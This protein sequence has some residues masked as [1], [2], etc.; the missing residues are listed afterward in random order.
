[1]QRGPPPPPGRVH[2]A[3][4]AVEQAGFALGGQVIGKY[5]NFMQMHPELA[6]YLPVREHGPGLA[7]LAKNALRMGSAFFYQLPAYF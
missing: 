4:Q 2:R 7:A 6:G 5:S 1:M 3:K